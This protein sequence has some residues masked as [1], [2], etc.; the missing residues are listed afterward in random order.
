MADQLVK[1]AQLPGV[2]LLVLAAVGDIQQDAKDRLAWLAD[3]VSSD[4]LILD[5]LELARLLVAYGELCPR[6]GTWLAGAG[7]GVC[8]Y[9][10]A[11]RRRVVRPPFTILTL[12]DTSVGNAKRFTAHILV[13]QGLSD[14]EV[15][16]RV[17]LA[18]PRLR[19]ERYA[20]NE[21]VA[22]VHGTRQ[23]DVI[24]LFVYEDATDRPFANWI[25]RAL[26]V[27]PSLKGPGPALFGDPDAQDPAL[28][29][30]W[31]TT[32]EAMAEL[33]SDRPDKGTYLTALDAYILDI[34]PLIAETRYLLSG[35]PTKEAEHA[36][37]R[38]AERFDAVRRPDQTKAAPHE[39]TDLD[40]LLAAIDGD[41]LNIGLPFGPL[42]PKTWP[43]A[44]QRLWLGRRALEQYD[45]DRRRFDFEREK[46]R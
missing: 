43:E 24:F 13:P 41:I 40:N 31:N 42:G 5:R 44:A 29:V 46:V 8:G 19:A 23:A 25:C 33:L 1:A 20:R 37:S 9:R 39:L 3:K 27:A 22:T 14:D 16:N 2:R 17:R 4:W 34:E 30:D 10:R 32:Y 6:D 38:L 36:L 7:C 15:E 18:I 26:W 28:R 12:E 11:S 35:N 45:T 21:R